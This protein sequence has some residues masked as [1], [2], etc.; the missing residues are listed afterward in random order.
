[1]PVASC[2][3]SSVMPASSGHSGAIRLAPM[4]NA[5]PAGRGDRQ[6]RYHPP[7]ALLAFLFL[8]TMRAIHR[9]ESAGERPG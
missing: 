2:Q 9:A 7:D 6:R 5:M 8:G 4:A 1:M 3:S